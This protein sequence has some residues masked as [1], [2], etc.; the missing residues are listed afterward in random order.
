MVLNPTLFFCY[1][2]VCGKGK[3]SR[4]NHGVKGKTGSL[5]KV[6]GM[7]EV[8]SR[9][10]VIQSKKRQSNTIGAIQN[11]FGKNMAKERQTRNDK[12]IYG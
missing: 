4:S 1:G 7:L 10:K 2:L 11:L 9:Q 8:Q 5:F 12:K 6:S 3:G